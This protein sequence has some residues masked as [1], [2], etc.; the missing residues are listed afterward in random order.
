M[1]LTIG[2]KSAA[3]TP[4]TVSGVPLPEGPSFIHITKNTANPIS[5]K[6]KA[7][8]FSTFDVVFSFTVDP[9]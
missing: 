4:S 8:Y 3:N 6:T 7:K 1:P 2:Y 9:P 5:A